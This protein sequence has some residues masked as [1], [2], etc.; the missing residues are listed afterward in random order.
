MKQLIG[1][2]INIFIFMFIAVLLGNMGYGYTTWQFWVILISMA[3]VQINSGLADH[4]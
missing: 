4:Y 2:L 1:A 3:I